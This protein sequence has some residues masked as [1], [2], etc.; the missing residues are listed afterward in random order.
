MRVQQRLQFAEG[1]V[2]HT[3]ARL[4]GKAHGRCSDGLRVAIDGEHTTFG[5]QRSEDA[6]RMPTPTK[7][8][9]DIQTIAR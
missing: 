5:S 8:G 2:D 4:I 3:Q 6:C 9:I 1:R 7:S